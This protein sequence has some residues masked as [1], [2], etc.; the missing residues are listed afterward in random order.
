M[1]CAILLAL[2]GLACSQ[3]AAGWLGGLVGAMAHRGHL[4]PMIRGGPSSESMS[5]AAR[6]SEAS[7]GPWSGMDVTMRPSRALA[8][9]GAI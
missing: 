2:R 4:H 1:L 3:R 7:L 5:G 9:S 6:L 8:V